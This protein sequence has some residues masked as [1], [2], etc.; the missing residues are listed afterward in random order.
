[1]DAF[2]VSVAS[3]VKTEVLIANEVL[4]VGCARFQ[5]K[6]KARMGGG[7]T[8]LVPH[9]LGQIREMRRR[10]VWLEMDGSRLLTK[11][12]RCAVSMVLESCRI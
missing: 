7:T 8:V 10:S 11:R 6:S 1:M 4:A 5:E 9:S 2:A 12:V 3:V